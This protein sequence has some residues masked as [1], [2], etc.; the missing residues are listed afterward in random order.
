M[1]FTRSQLITLSEASLEGAEHLASK[2][3]S[4]GD[5][6]PSEVKAIKRKIKAFQSI[7]REIDTHIYS[8]DIYKMEVKGLKQ[9]LL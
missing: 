5:Y 6:T 3:E 7:G 8:S 1:T 4:E 9:I 2:L